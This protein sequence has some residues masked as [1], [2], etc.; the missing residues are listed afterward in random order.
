MDRLAVTALLACLAAVGGL[1]VSPLL[2]SVIQRAP[3][4]D[5]LL[6][7]VGRCPVCGARR[8]AMACPVCGA[9]RPWTDVGVALANA[10]LWAAA[11]LRFG[12]G[13]AL[14]VYLAFFSTVL[15]LSVVDLETYLL[16]NRITYPALVGSS[17]AIVVV[18]LVSA[19]DPRRAVAKAG[20]GAV[21][22][23]GFL[24]ALLALFWAA[25][26]REGLGLGDVKLAALLG[27]HV[28]WISP[29]LVI[30]ALFVAGVVGLAAGVVALVVRSGANRPYPFGPWLAA[31]AVTVILASGPLLDAFGV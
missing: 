8:A 19:D 4:D 28:G 17:A 24:L 16:P 10:A 23:A 20:V 3:G 22:W 5:A 14:V 31:G 9:T 11:A 6:T 2:T 26:G 7:G 27:L 13:L 1:A 15:V 29:V 25:T 18:S 30:P 12:P 21:G